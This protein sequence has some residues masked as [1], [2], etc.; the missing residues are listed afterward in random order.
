MRALSVMALPR[1]D[2]TAKPLTLT[3]LASTV[4]LSDAECDELMAKCEQVFCEHEAAA[5]NKPKPDRALSTEPTDDKRASSGGAS[6]GEAST[7]DSEFNEEASTTDDSEASDAEQ[8]PPSKKKRLAATK[9]P[10]ACALTQ[11]QIETVERELELGLQPNCSLAQRAL[12]AIKAI[13]D[14]RKE[15]KKARHGSLA[16]GATCRVKM[17]RACALLSK[18]E[19]A[20]MQGSLWVKEWREQHGAYLEEKFRSQTAGLA[21]LYGVLANPRRVAANGGSMIGAERASV[22]GR[23]LRESQRIEEAL[24]A[25]KEEDKQFEAWCAPPVTAAPACASQPTVPHCPLRCPVP[26]TC[27]S[28]PCL[29]RDGRAHA[30]LLH[31]SAIELERALIF[32]AVEARAEE[33]GGAAEGST[34]FKF[35][36]FAACYYGEALYLAYLVGG[37]PTRA[38]NDRHGW[39]V[40]EHEQHR[41]L[42]TST[43][44]PLERTQVLHAA[45]A[46]G[47]RRVL[48]PLRHRQAERGARARGLHRVAAVLRP[49]R[50]WLHGLRVRLGDAVR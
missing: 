41:L 8:E 42:L 49:A 19:V 43:R 5:A 6:P 32:G 27:P 36:H 24:A 34:L 40:G 33:W 50:R 29:H 11:E 31:R 38:Q 45:A 13:K 39:C 18:L 46:G 21:W 15:L 7:D 35:V 12:K 3:F 1:A 26:E 25:L 37:T 48:P 44:L 22:S 4:P 16:D 20:G 23:R 2:T 10:K 28:A 47:H 17:Q 30:T 9:K 14:L